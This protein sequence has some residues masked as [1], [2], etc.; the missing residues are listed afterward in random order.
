M[1]HVGLVKTQL[2]FKAVLIR[3]LDEEKN[4]VATASGFLSRQDGALY[5]Y[6]CWHVVTG[7][8][9][10]DLKV[11]NSLPNRRYL[12]IEMPESHAQSGGAVVLGGFQTFTLPLYRERSGD[13]LPTWQQD[14]RHIPHA[15]LN[16]VGIYVPF[17]HDTVRLALD[18][19]TNVHEWQLIDDCIQRDAPPISLG[20][21]AYIVGFPYGFS[22][23]GQS[24]P[25]P[26][27]LTRFVA[28]IR[29]GLRLQE[30]LLE[31]PGA[32]SMSGAPVFIEDERGIRFVG[33][34]T[35]LIYPDH[36]IS[37]N[38]KTTALGTCGDLSMLI[39]RATTMAATPDES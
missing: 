37:N 6:T 28:A 14:K 39:L 7:Y 18:S 20:D 4:P 33:Q 24:N 29:F 27:S 36:V 25:F 31:S 5:L 22:A 12:Q 1:T 21:K 9:R 34:Y 16:N 32:P 38:E 10:N 2:P 35:G 8:D 26:V 13:L 11:G 3:C 19:S 23:F 17:W 30:F 15:D